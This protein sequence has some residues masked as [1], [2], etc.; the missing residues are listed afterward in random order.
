MDEETL[1]L[2][3]NLVS[4]SYIE[5]G[6]QQITKRRKLVKSLLSERRLP[7]QGWDDLTIESFVQVNNLYL[8]ALENPS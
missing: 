4:R 1:K 2:A 7:E 6:G 8:T 5:Q 3:T